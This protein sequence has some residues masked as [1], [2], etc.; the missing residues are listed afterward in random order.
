MIINIIINII[1]IFAVVVVVAALHFEYI[2][3]I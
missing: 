3:F 2:R 1:T